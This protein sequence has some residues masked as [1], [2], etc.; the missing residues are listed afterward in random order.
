M[1]LFSPSKNNLIEEILK[2]LLILLFLGQSLFLTK[3]ETFHGKFLMMLI[4]Y[5]FSTVKHMR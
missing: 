5:L 4:H 3:V 1:L 2:M